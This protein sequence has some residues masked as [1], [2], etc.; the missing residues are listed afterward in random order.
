M[1]KKYDAV[2]EMRSIRERLQKEYQK[3][4]GL[5]KKR[6]EQIHAKYGMNVEKER[7]MLVSEKRATYSHKKM[8]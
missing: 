4:P 5:R 8:T 3:N 7:Q 1:K 2:E 6:L